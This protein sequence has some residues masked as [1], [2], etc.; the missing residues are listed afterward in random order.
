VTFSGLPF[1]SP[2]G[3]LVRFVDPAGRVFLLHET[4][5]QNQR[6]LRA[7]MSASATAET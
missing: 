6:S 1:E 3:H 5:Q 2:I 7:G 4:T